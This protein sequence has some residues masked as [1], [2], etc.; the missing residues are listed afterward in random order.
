MSRE[1]QL[2]WR[3][4]RWRKL[5]IYQTTKLTARKLKK[6]GYTGQNALSDFLLV[7]KP[8]P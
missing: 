8:S 3:T 4:A 6:A 7:R 5:L 1:G 2:Q